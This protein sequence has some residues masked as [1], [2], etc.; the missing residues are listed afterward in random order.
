MDLVGWYMEA[1]DRELDYGPAPTTKSA[2][3]KFLRIF[4]RWLR[5]L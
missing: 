5:R 2:G 1:Y 4:K 3:S